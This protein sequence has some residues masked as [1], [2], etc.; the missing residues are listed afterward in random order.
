[1]AL[2]KEKGG[3]YIVCKKD[4]LD[5]KDEKKDKKFAEFDTMEEAEAYMKKL[6]FKGSFLKVQLAGKKRV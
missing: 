1:M 6:H 3:K 5:P 2:I 4:K